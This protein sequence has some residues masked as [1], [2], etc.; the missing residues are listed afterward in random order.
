MRVERIGSA[1][2]YLGDCREI[3]P[4]IPKVSAVVTDPPYGINGGSGTVGKLRA[5]KHD[6]LSFE[7]T[8]DNIANIVVPAF[9][10]ALDRADGRGVIT[11]GPKC[12][13]FY[14]ALMRLDVCIS[15]RPVP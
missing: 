12:L 1:T 2:L 14:P 11:P 3:I 10:A 4:Q 5:H 13:T 8:P 7:D 9:R 6:Y 15:P